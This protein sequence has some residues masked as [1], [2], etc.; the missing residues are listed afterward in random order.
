LDKIEKKNYFYKVMKQIG[1]ISDTHSLYY[2][3]IDEHFKDVDEIWHAGDIGDLKVMERLNKIA[4]SKA[5][6]GNIDDPDIREIYPENLI[7]ECEEVKVLIRHI[8]N[9]PGRYTR[10]TIDLIKKH[11]PDLV[12]TGHSHILKVMY[13]K[14]L[15]HLHINPGAA[16]LAGFH[17][18]CTLIRLKFDG[19]EMK[20]LEVIEFDKSTKNFY[21]QN[22]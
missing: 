7:F 13:D 3:K 18:V 21:S 9:Y 16:G 2:P 15:E 12:I 14:N 10:K 4:P 20:D 5:V 8:C 1:L 17:K 22:R 6:Y 19:A 11:K